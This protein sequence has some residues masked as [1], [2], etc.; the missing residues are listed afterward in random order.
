MGQFTLSVDES[1]SEPTMQDVKYVNVMFN[2]WP[3]AIEVDSLEW[4]QDEN[5]AYKMQ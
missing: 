3:E 5:Q 2:P 1:C 4:F